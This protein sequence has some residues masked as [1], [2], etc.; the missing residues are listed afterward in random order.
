M[1]FY[2]LLLSL[3]EFFHLRRSAFAEIHVCSWFHLTNLEVTS[4][5]RFCLFLYCFMMT[6]SILW[7]LLTHRFWSPVFCDRQL[8]LISMCAPVFTVSESRSYFVVVVLSLS[9]FFV[10]TSSIL[11]WLL[12]HRFWS[13]SFCEGQLS[14]DTICAANFFA[15]ESRSYFIVELLSLSTLFQYGKILSLMVTDPS[16][17]EFCL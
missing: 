9:T 4:S 5:L 10:L 15:N 12:I 17:L 6:K 3:L 16:L 7:W 1:P 11:W 14:L 8:S 2:T 13:S